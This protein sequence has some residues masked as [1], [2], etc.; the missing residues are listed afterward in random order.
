MVLLIIKLLLIYYFVDRILKFK[1]VVIFFIVILVI[2]R[3]RRF[4]AGFQLP[5]TATGGTVT[6]TMTYVSSVLP[7]ASPE[8]DAPH[9]ITFS[10]DTIYP[11]NSFNN[12]VT[13][14]SPSVICLFNASNFSF[15]SS[16]LSDDLP[17]GFLPL[18]VLRTVPKS[19][20]TALFISFNRMFC[21]FKSG[22]S[23]GYFLRHLDSIRKTIATSIELVAIPFVSMALFGT[24]IGLETII[25]VVL[26]AYG[27][28]LLQHL[29]LKLL[30]LRHLNL[31]QIQMPVLI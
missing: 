3:R 29:H 13:P 20:T 18:P 14:D 27:T 15:S 16:S 7:Q 28:F 21:G 25:A 26:V 11:L 2:V 10:A 24:D 4:T 6:L 5:E 19:A 1:C 23:T 31:L 30:F 9:V 12:T 17:S 8:D 22:V